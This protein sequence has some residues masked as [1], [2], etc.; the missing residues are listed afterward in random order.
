VTLKEKFEIQFESPLKHQS[1][2]GTLWDLNVPEDASLSV[3]LQVDK[4]E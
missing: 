1:F 2:L 3:K 4:N